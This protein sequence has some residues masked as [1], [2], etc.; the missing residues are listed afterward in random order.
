[1][2]GQAQA[3]AVSLL[4]HDDTEPYGAPLDKPSAGMVARHLS[5]IQSLPSLLCS[6]DRQTLE[7]GENSHPARESVIK[8]CESVQLLWQQE[9]GA[10]YIFLR[11]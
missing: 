5:R 3:L 8:A 10:W 6:N 1:M 9:E 11:I 7:S 4:L 2:V